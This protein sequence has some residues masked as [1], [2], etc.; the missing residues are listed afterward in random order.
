[1]DDKMQ[2]EHSSI[3]MIA[4]SAI[5]NDTG[6]FLD[7]QVAQRSLVQLFHFLFT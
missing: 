3:A 2:L 7:P 6:S 4:L 1:M 5:G